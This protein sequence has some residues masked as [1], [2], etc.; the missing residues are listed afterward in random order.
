VEAGFKDVRAELRYVRT[1][2]HAEVVELRSDINTRFVGLERL[3]TALWVSLTGGM[4]A[5]VAALIATNL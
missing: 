4:A 3:I 1:D 5:F 2:A